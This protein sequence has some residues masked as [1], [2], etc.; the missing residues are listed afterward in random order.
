MK[1]DSYNEFFQR[2]RFDFPI[3]FYHVD[4]THQ[5]FC[6]PY[7]WHMEYEIIWIKQGA[8]TLTLN[9]T[10]IHAVSGDVIFVRDGVIHGG[11]PADDDTVYDCVVFDM[12]KLLADSH[13]FKEKIESILKHDMLVNKYMPVDTPHIP[14]VVKEMFNALKNANDGYELIVTGMLYAFFGFVLQYHLY[15]YPK[16]ANV[17]EKNRTRLSQLKKIFALIDAHYSEPLTLANLAETAGLS[18]NY[19]CRYFKKITQQNPIDYLNSYRIEMACLKLLHSTDSITDIALSCGFNDV[20]YFIKIFRRYKGISPLK[21][22]K[23][24]QSADGES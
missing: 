13:T 19:F 11:T 4:S 23:A 14:I 8:L 6:M 15:H 22:Q 2:G 21:F 10:S 5:R 16:A 18:P 1:H 17:L 24:Q 9:E 12:R 3:E 7:H 20:S